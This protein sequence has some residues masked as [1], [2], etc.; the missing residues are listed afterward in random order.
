M[1]AL[2][3]ILLSIAPLLAAPQTPSTS[4]AAADAAF[5]EGRFDEAAAGYRAAIKADRQNGK[6]HA[7][8]VRTCLKQHKVAEAASAAKEGL[9]AVPRSAPLRSAY[10][11]VCFRQG[12]LY[13]A[14]T[15]FVEALNVDPKCARAH[16]GL[17]RLYLAERRNRSAK[18]RIVKAH[19]LDPDDPEILLEWAYTLPDR[20]SQLAALKEYLR[21]ATN[22]DPEDLANIRTSIAAT[23][24]LGTGDVREITDPRRAYK[25]DLRET[26]E[27]RGPVQ[28]YWLPVMVNGVKLRLE[29]D[30]GADGIILNRKAAEK[31]HLK[32]LSSGA[33]V[34]GVG[35]EGRR[36]VSIMLADTVRVADLEIRHQHVAVFSAQVLTDHDGLIGSNVFS[37]FLVHLDFPER[38][39]ELTPPEAGRKSIFEDFWGVEREMRPDFTPVHVFGHLLLADTMI[40]NVPGFLMAIDSGAY[41]HLLSTPSVKK[42]SSL[43]TADVQLT[44]ISGRASETTYTGRQI[45][46]A[47]ARLAQKGQFLSTDLTSQ[48]NRL[49]VEMSG[50]IGLDA[51]R[52]L[53]VTIDYTNGLVRMEYR[54]TA[55]DLRH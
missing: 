19:E 18:E 1:G 40:D 45:T 23:T 47:F 36:D 42:L 46:L 11:D 39:L 51:L 50:F 37:H 25:M 38:K 20:P 35:D 24:A 5:Q 32:Q 28:A 44:G 34:G 54:R 16:F 2:G 4:L 43:H 31:C 9:L 8:L 17:A 10:G 49:G 21:R 53:D 15:E 6:A 52:L 22:E 29:L 12:D 7:G 30:S 13:A 48:N 27:P 55:N 33:R 14:Q 26:L 41:V 3:V